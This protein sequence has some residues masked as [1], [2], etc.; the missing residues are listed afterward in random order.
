MIVSGL[1]T[2]GL[3]GVM[4]LAIV[5]LAYLLVATAHH[6]ISV[7]AGVGGIGEGREMFKLLTP[8]D[9]F[10]N[11]VPLTNID[12]FKNSQ[13]T[14]TAAVMRDVISQWFVIL[15]G[16][17]I[18]LL[19][20]VLI[21]IAIRLLIS[22]AE[23]KAKEKETLTAWVVS[24]GILFTIQVYAVFIIKV[25]NFLLS[26]L[27]KSLEAGNNN[28]MSEDVLSAFNTPVLS[29]LTLLIIYG[30]IVRYTATFFFQYIKRMIKVAF[31]LMISPLIVITY[32][33]DKYGDKKAQALTSW[34]RQF[35]SE[36]LIQPFHALIY[37]ILLNLSTA[38]NASGFLGQGIVGIVIL[39]FMLEA[40]KIVKNIFGVK[41]S[42][43]MKDSDK[44]ANTLMHNK[45]LDYTSKKISDYKVPEKIVHLSPMG[46]FGNAE[47]NS[48]IVDNDIDVKDQT[49]PPAAPAQ[50][51]SGNTQPIPIVPASGSS[52]QTSQNQ[53]Q[54]QNQSGNTQPIPVPNQTQIGNTQIDPPKED[55]RQKFKDKNINLRIAAAKKIVP[56]GFAYAGAALEAG[57]P[58][59]SLVKNAFQGA[60]TGY[61]LGTGVETIAEGQIKKIKDKKEQKENY[62]ERVKIASSEL[63]KNAAI[64][65]ALNKIDY[66]YT[67]EEGQ[68][69]VLDWIEKVEKTNDN[70]L[71]TI[72]EKNRQRLLNIYKSR[73]GLTDV[74]AS[75]KIDELE[76]DA[77]AYGTNININEYTNEEKEFLTSMIMLKT[78]Y[79]KTEIEDLTD[80]VDPNVMDTVKATVLNEFK[81]SNVEYVTNN[82]IAEQSEEETID[83][84]NRKLEDDYILSVRA[85]NKELNQ[86][87]EDLKN[88]KEEYEDKYNKDESELKQ[89][90]IN[91]KMKIDKYK[92]EHNLKLKKYRDAETKIHDI[93]KN[94]YKLDYDFDLDDGIK[95]DKAEKFIKAEEK[96]SG[97]T[98]NTSNTK[99]SGNTGNTGNSGNNGNNG[100]I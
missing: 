36:V 2:A 39:R 19:L 46:R 4:F 11:K 74:T 27:E 7:I 14:E 62:S 100:T 52:G 24:V 94:D 21:F 23:G 96:L 76:E 20:F 58:S 79:E 50:S 55:K 64:L 31:L 71:S 38:M 82:E 13:S 3:L 54:G 5:F 18:V 45:F 90:M 83:I 51:A 53:Q 49:Q 6:I 1:V 60:S 88:A 48:L 85:K 47:K 73:D 30:I 93:Y 67:T 41:P 70:T 29:W 9:I 89:D 15:M 66:D 22:N 84:P 26:V 16:I 69:I 68:K 44:L 80:L 97:N 77:Y 8:G 25:N 43:N 75:M 98:K 63:G 40:E 95:L 33:L 32:S 56:F 59:D 92:T 17:A 57:D 28:F 34:M 72:Y 78:K 91:S 86:L 61:V 42:A 10:F 81:N 65:M 35:T 87:Y 37:L 99:K 12:F